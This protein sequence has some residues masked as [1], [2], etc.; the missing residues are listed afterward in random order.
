MTLK[1]KWLGALLLPLCLTS[2][3][4]DE[5]PDVNPLV[6]AKLVQMGEYL[7][8]LPKFQL[9]S[10]LSQ[11]MVVGT[12]QKIKVLGTSQVKVD[13]KTRLR[14]TLATD[15]LT[16]DFFYNGQKFTQYSPA[17]NFYT[18][19]DAPPT[20]LET[21]QAVEKFYGLQL[22]MEDL[23]RFGLDD[24]QIKALTVAAY[25]GPST[26]N[27]KLC[28]H[29]AFRRPGVDWQLWMTRSEKPLPCQLI[30]TRTDKPGQPEYSAVY[31]WNLGPKF[32]PA[33]FTFKP[34]KDDAEI[35]FK[36]IAE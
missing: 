2:W 25:V 14:A 19:V 16:R 12:G 29:L 8:S 21:I 22:P 36:K 30:L 23:F 24:T 18:T 20:V 33:E 7:R 32:T 27:G 4:A 6:V 34:G 10:Q 11:D 28:D 15:S 17:L 5:V 31:K 9:D 3:A 1:S 26:V 13:G 35:A